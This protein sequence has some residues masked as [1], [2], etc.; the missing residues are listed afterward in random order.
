MADNPTIGGVQFASDDVG[1]IQHPLTLLEF[2]LPDSPVRV[3]ATNPLPVDD[4]TGS[5]A[6]YFAVT[7]SDSIALTT[8]AKAIYVGVAG[9]MT[10]KNGSGGTPVTFKNV[11]AGS[12]VPVRATH[13]L[14]SGTSAT[15]IVAL[16]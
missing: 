12:Y 7:P 14:A 10:V 5:S 8:G 1:G 16:A 9:D 6:T 2:G 4:G 15:S 13:V 3:S 11:P